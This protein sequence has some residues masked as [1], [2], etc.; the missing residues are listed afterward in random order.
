MN[1]PKIILNDRKI[2]SSEVY[3]YYQSLA[4]Q[5]IKNQRNSNINIKKNYSKEK[6]LNWFSN[7]DIKQKF[8]ICS[9]YNNWFSNIIYQMMEYYHFDSVIEFSPTDVYLEFKKNNLDEYNCLKSELTFNNKI[10]NCDNYMTFFIGENKVKKLSGIPDENELININLKNHFELLFLDNLRFIT[11]DEFNDTISFSYDL[12]EHSERLFEFF[13]YFSKQQCFIT[14]IKPILEK[15]N[16]YNFSLPDW[17]Y[18]YQSYSFCQLLIIFFEQI[19]SVYYQLY[20]YEKEIPQLSIDQK[21]TNFFKT[22]ENI[23]EYLLNKIKNKNDLIINKQECYEKLNSKTQI[24]KYNYYQ[25]KSAF[26]YSMAFGPSFFE[27]NIN[28]E[29]D[30][31]MKFNFLIELIKTDINRFIDKIS[32]IGTKDCFKYANFIYNTIYQQLIKQYSD[33]C[34]Q[35]LILE[36]KN[37]TQN[38]S[39]TNKSKKNKRK[40]K[41]K[42]KNENE[43]EIKDIHNTNNN[44]ISDDYNE[45]E[46]KKI[47]IEDGEEEIEEIPADYIIQPKAEQAQKRRYCC[48]QSRQEC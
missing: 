8:K 36:E 31:N 19:I 35:E 6:I 23:K 39:V 30:F 33:S 41:K 46:N 38:E 25:N 12:F 42:K 22:N 21:Y 27:K 16:C 44:I 13:N 2:I 4:Q 26:V 20:L 5:L 10:K 28:K 43:N 1:I 3:Y 34:Y 45:E 32:L 37:K 17:V 11:L 18:N 47:I 24:D 14:L 48:F 29:R 40:K 7:L 9:I 15:N